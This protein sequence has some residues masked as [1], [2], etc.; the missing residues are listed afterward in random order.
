MDLFAADYMEHRVGGAR[1]NQECADIIKGAQRIFP[2]LHVK[3]EDIVEDD[4]LLAVRVIFD[5][6]HKDTFMGIEAADK[7]IRWEA[8]EFLRLKDGIITET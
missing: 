8:M 7:N 3:I 6:T 5:A 4:D 2:D 1:T